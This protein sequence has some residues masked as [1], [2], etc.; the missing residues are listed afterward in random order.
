[1]VHA[2]DRDGFVPLV[3]VQLLFQRLLAPKYFVEIFHT[4]HTAF[5]DDCLV[6]FPACDGAGPGA[7]TQ[8][9]AH[10]LVLRY[11]VPFLL[12][13]VAGDGRFDAY[14]GPAPGVGFTATGV[15]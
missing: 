1:M 14:L 13:H 6:F 9:E 8:D 3:A 7:L 5:I 11:A 2:G 10:Q 4:G 15:D 12:H